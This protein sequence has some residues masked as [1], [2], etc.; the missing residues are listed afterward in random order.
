[1]SR[2]SGYWQQ[3]KAKEAEL[4]AKYKTVSTSP[5]RL[6]GETVESHIARRKQANQEQDQISKELRDWVIEEDIRHHM[7]IARARWPDAQVTREGVWLP[8]PRCKQVRIWDFDHK[9]SELCEDCEHDQD[10]WTLKRTCKQCGSS[11]RIGSDSDHWRFCS[12][13]CK[14]IS[15]LKG[16]PPW[17][18]EEWEQIQAELGTEKRHSGF[19]WGGTRFDYRSSAVGSHYKYDLGDPEATEEQTALFGAFDK[20]LGSAEDPHR[21]LQLITNIILLMKKKGAACH[22]EIAGRKDDPEAAESDEP[23]PR[24]LRGK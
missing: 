1:M 21:R 8:C 22:R 5:R 24:Y 2:D 11:Y 19:D 6:K 7:A 16:D 18:R 15:G 17:T 4:T 23:L 9:D 13:Y 14:W 12:A 20:Y 10:E 3:R